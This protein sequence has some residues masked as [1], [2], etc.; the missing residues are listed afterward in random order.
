MWCPHAKKPL[1]QLIQRR[2][3]VRGQGTEPRSLTS[4][5]HSAMTLASLDGVLITWA[6]H[7]SYCIFVWWLFIGSRASYEL[8]EMVMD[9]PRRPGVLRFMGSQRVGHDWA[10]E[11]NWTEG[12]LTW[13]PVRVRKHT[14]IWRKTLCLYFS[15]E[16]IYIFITFSKVDGV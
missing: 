10:T 8:R 9:R 3:V 16:G 7:T 1:I 2:D 6:H 14:D 4:L 15:K 12:F 11:L 5:R 13:V